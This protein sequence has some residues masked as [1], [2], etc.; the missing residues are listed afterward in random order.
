MSLDF[1]LIYPGENHNNK[2]S[3]IFVRENG[4]TKEIPMEELEEKFPGKKPVVSLADDDEGEVFH[5]NITHNL[6]DMAK[7]AGIYEC[8]WR[9]SE[10]G[11]EKAKDII[12]RLKTGIEM[13]YDVPAFFK[14]FDADNGWG[15]YDD[16]LPWLK[17]V[18][19]ACEEYPG[20]VIK[21][22]V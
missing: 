7:Q 18:L 4:M 1:Y 3:G 9:P 14:Q 11:F 19:S 16:F 13:M 12:D 15:T 8:L 10:N 17:N 2:G 22:W 5:A 6:S 20:A 21:V